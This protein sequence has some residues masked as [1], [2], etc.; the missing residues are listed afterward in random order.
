MVL[1]WTLGA[2]DCLMDIVLLYHLH[3]HPHIA[4]LKPFI[5]LGLKTKKLLKIGLV[6]FILFYTRPRMDEDE[7]K[8]KCE[9]SKIRWEPIHNECEWNKLNKIT[10][11]MNED[12]EN[13]NGIGIHN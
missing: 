12:E 10:I 2:Q 11:K 1:G 6:Y 4:W 7:A 9:L 8:L 13:L 5:L 3:F